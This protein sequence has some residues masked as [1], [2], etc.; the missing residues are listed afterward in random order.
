MMLWILCGL[1]HDEQPLPNFPLTA[2][3]VLREQQDR[4]SRRLMRHMT[5][6]VPV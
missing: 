4:R 2:G 3:S 6:I 5:A 1:E